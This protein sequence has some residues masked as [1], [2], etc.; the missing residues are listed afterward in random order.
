MHLLQSVTDLAEVGHGFEFG[1][2]LMGVFAV[3]EFHV[4][5]VNRAVAPITK[6]L[7][8]KELSTCL[9]TFLDTLQI[10]ML[11]FLEDSDFSFCLLDLG[12]L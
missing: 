8:N 7:Y 3:A 5:S 6:L 10:Q 4:E 11:H 2:G 9:K 1:Q 12:L